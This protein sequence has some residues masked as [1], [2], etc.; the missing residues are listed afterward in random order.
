MSERALGIFGDLRDPMTEEEIASDIRQRE[1]EDRAW[2]VAHPIILK[3]YGAK[4]VVSDRAL[5]SRW[6]KRHAALIESIQQ[7]EQQRQEELIAL[8]LNEEILP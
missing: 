5:S 1:E 7:A 3:K 2:R 8:I 6:L 4:L